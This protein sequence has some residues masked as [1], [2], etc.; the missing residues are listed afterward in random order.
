MMRPKRGTRLIGLYKGLVGGSG[1]AEIA[2]SPFRVG[3]LG[4]KKATSKKTEL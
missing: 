4:Q 3:N 1:A 2:A